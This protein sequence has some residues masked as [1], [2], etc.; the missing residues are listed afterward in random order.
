SRIA[1]VGRNGCGKTTLL[2]LIAG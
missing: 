1:V 2:K